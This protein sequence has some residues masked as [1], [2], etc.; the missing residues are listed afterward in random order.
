MTRTVE[1]GGLYFVVIS[2]QEHA[3]GH[4]CVLVTCTCQFHVRSEGPTALIVGVTDN[5]LRR[6]E[7]ERARRPEQYLHLELVMS[8]RE[9]TMVDLARQSAKRVRDARLALDGEGW[10]AAGNHHLGL[11]AILGEDGDRGFIL[12]GCCAHREVESV[13]WSEWRSA[14]CAQRRRAKATQG[15][16]AAT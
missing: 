15:A 10:L 4:P 8:G 12:D 11:R 5:P 16:E 14:A 6:L 13:D 2:I 7:E 9:D 1:R 3:C